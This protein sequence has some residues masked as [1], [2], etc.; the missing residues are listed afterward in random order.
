MPVYQLN[1]QIDEQG[2]NTLIQAG[3]LVTIVKSAGGGTP[4]VW[5]TFNPMMM[6]TVTWTEQYSVYAST[7]Q[8][9]DGAQIITQSTQPAV[10]GNTY[11]L[12]GGQFDNGQPGLPAT[13]FG[14]TNND[15]NFSVGGNQ[16]V[17]SGLY[18]G[19]IVNGGSTASPLNA[20]GIPY[21]QSGTFA[22]SEQ[23]QV[24]ASYYQNNGL[25][26]SSVSALALRVDLTQGP[27]TIHYD[28]ASNQ[29]AMGPLSAYGQ[30]A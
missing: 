5:V 15:P 19:A 12:S 26:I 8:I 9:Q 6:N 1:I 23:V 11:T 17:T 29:F 21:Q 16:M 14:V 27:Q 30:V 22:P 4:V 24:F 3:Q 18:Q 13:Q 2:L 28:D 7:T 25:V 20:V 10:G